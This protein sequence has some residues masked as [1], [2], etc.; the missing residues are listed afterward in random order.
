MAKTLDTETLVCPFCGHIYIHKIYRKGSASICP[1]CG[2]RNDTFNNKHP[3]NLSRMKSPILKE[4]ANPNCDDGLGRPFLF[5]TFNKHQRY[6]SIECQRIMERKKSTE[7]T[8]IWKK[9]NPERAKAIDKRYYEKKR[10]EKE[11][12]ESKYY[13]EDFWKKFMKG[14]K[15]CM[16]E[17]DEYKGNKMIVLKRDEN[18]EYPFKFGLRKAQLI[19]DNFEDIKA[20][21]EENSE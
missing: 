11:E 21:V 1:K 13:K 20:W 16:I 14:D 4:C 5:Y 8:R 10:K 17:F 6:C 18:D 12:K 2:K 15:K 19:L 7:R 3:K 9:N